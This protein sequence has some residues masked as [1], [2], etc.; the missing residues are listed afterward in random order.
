M[1]NSDMRKRLIRNMDWHGHFSHSLDEIPEIRNLPGS[2]VDGCRSHKEVRAV[3][4]GLLRKIE[5]LNHELTRLKNE[6]RA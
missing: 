6:V 1:E 5:C 3:V 2:G 4:I